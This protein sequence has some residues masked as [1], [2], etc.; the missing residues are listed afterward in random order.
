MNPVSVF[1][2]LFII[3][4]TSYVFLQDLFVAGSDTSSTTV[5]W[6]MAELLRNPSSMAKA[7]DELARVIGLTRSVEESDID[8]LPYLQAVVK[9]TFRLHPPGPLLLPRQAQETVTITSYTIPQG[10]RVLVNVW[11]MGRDEA[12]WHEPERFIPERFLGSTLDYKGGDFELIPFGAGRRV[13]PGMPLATRMVHMVLATLLNQ[14]E[15][16]LPVEVERTG[17]KM[18]EKFGLSLT[19]AVPLCAIAAPI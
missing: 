18:D 12:I 17:I 15:W 11:A 6:A 10:S 4:R 19:K 7:H 9:E 16:R 8:Q 14:F 5:E 1:L 13:C 3:S 2:L